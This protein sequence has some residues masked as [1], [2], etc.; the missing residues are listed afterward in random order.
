[1]AFS[2]LHQKTILIEMGSLNYP[3]KRTY[4]SSLKR[5]TRAGKKTKTQ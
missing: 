1:L 5:D 2:N 3:I 4:A